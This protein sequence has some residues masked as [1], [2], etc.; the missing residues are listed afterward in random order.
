MANPQNIMRAIHC[1]KLP[2]LTSSEKAL[3]PDALIINDDISTSQIDD[4]L[5][6][7]NS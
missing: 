3:R 1:A 2:A 4:A 7:M 6:G 5:T